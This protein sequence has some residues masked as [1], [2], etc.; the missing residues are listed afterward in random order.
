MSPSNPERKVE[1]GKKNRDQLTVKSAKLSDD[2]RTVFLEFADI[3]PVMQMRISYNLD[4]ADGELVKGE[5]H[6][7]IHALG[8]DRG[9]PAGR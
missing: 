2:G 5:V 7:T 4:A 9:M 8:N 1:R 6:N 3:A